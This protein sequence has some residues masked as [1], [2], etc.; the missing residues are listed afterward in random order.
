MF[1]KT[2]GRSRSS[3]HISTDRTTSQRVA[4]TMFAAARRRRATCGDR[5]HMI[6]GKSAAIIRKVSEHVG[7]DLGAG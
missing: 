7:L 1:G 3:P 2:G 4:T 6:S 5:T